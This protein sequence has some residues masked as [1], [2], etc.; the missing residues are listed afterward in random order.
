MISTWNLI[1]CVLTV[2][3]Y[4]FLTGNAPFQAPKGDEALHPLNDNNNNNNNNNVYSTLERIKSGKF[5]LPM[6]CSE[7]AK[8]LL[9]HLLVKV[10]K[11]FFFFLPLFFFFFFFVPIRNQKTEFHLTKY[12][13]IHGWTQQAAPGTWQPLAAPHRLLLLPFLPI[14]WEKFFILQ[15]RVRWQSTKAGI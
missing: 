15:K 5:H 14:D 8:N 6:E 2:I 4:V 13:V 7:A 1:H 3:L 12:Y 11:I 10:K 9:K